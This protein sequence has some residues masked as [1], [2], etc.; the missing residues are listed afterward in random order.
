M[1]CYDLLT[2][3]TAL[4]AHPQQLQVITLCETNCK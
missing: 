1:A 3:Y 4:S 2:T